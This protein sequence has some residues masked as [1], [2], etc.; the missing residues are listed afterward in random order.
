MLESPILFGLVKAPTS[1][2]TRPSPGGF[3]R[4]CDRAGLA[5]SCDRGG[6]WSRDQGGARSDDRGDLLLRRPKES[7]VFSP[8]W[9]AGPRFQGCCLGLGHG[10]LVRWWGATGTDSVAGARL[11]WGSPGE[12][13][14]LG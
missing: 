13:V 2:L 12:G 10:G 6:G 3:A 14:G 1:C 5:R 8:L 4:S 7:K 9:P 11:F